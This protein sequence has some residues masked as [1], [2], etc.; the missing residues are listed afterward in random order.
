VSAAARV[1]ALRA[2][3]CRER[4]RSGDCGRETCDCTRSTAL[5]RHSGD[6]RVRR[7]T[8]TAVIAT[9]FVGIVVAAW[10]PVVVA[11][12]VVEQ[13]R[14]PS[15]GSWFPKMHESTLL[16]PCILL[17]HFE[18]Y[19]GAVFFLIGRA[20]GKSDSSREQGPRAIKIHQDSARY[21]PHNKKTLGVEE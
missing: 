21:S 8:A 19:F 15:P 13:W 14:S 1:P 10:P 18:M 7:H 5:N 6:R 16:R 4:R 9:D 2:A 17:C 3:E 12:V 11:A 20:G